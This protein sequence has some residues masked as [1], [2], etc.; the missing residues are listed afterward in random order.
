MLCTAAKLAI[1]GSVLLS[2][3]AHS[4][5]AGGLAA[6]DSGVQSIY[7]SLNDKSCA[8]A[9][10]KSDPNDT[11][12]LVCRGVA[13]YVLQVRLVDSGRMSISVVSPAKHESPLNFQ[14]VIT[15]SMSELDDKAEWRVRKESGKVIP[16]ALIV[17]VM[18]HESERSPEKVTNTYLAVAKVAAEKACVTDRIPQGSKTDAEVESLADSAASRPCASRLPSAQP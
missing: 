14:N 12:Y 4:Q 1:A 11:P 5:G 18:A 10:D 9:I 13:G 6:A 16:I 2:I 8:T 17:R 7:T 3:C 15:R